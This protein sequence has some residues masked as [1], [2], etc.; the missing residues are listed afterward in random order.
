MVKE[1]SDEEVEK[2]LATNSSHYNIY[3]GIDYANTKMS[4]DDQFNPNDGSIIDK[5]DSSLLKLNKKIATKWQDKTYRS[6]ADLERFLYFGSAVTLGGYVANTRNFIMAVP[7][8]IAL[9]RGSIEMA[10]PKSAKHE[11]IQFEARGLPGKTMKYLNVMC[12]GLGI[13]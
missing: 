11:E 4:L 5:L 10:R 12:Y 3:K 8:A 2:K 9:L 6:K 1:E 7:V 13:Y